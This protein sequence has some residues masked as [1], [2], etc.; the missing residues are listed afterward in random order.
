MQS[1]GLMLLLGLG[2]AILLLRARADRYGVTK[3]GAGDMATAALIAGVLGARLLFLLQEPKTFWQN[4]FKWQFQGLTSF[5]G[6]IAGAIAVLLWARKR[7]IALPNVID[8]A[9]PAFLAA[10]AVGRIGCL[11]NGCCFGHQCPPG[12][13]YGVHVEGTKALHVP[14][15]LFDSAM[16]VAAV[17]LLLWIERRNVAPLVLTGWGLVLHGLARFV[18][19]F[20]RAGTDDEVARGL[21]SSTYLGSLPVTEAQVTALAMSLLG[22]IVLGFATRGRGGVRA[23]A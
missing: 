18:Y 8:L 7:K 15:Q 4:V 20:W 11:L 16:N 21:A 13:W 22:A 9:A 3:E 14:A 2:V 5:G 23:A 10:H 17:G 12:T 6:L 1:F 19:E